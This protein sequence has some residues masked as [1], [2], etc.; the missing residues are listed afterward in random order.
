MT[1]EF[2]NHAL[3]DLSESAQGAG[4]ADL[5]A[6]SAGYHHFVEK[7]S[8]FISPTES[9]ETSKKFTTARRVFW[10][11]VLSYLLLY[12]AF[13]ELLG[14]FSLRLVAISNDFLR[15]SLLLIA[16]ILVPWIGIGIAAQLLLPLASWCF[17]P[18]PL[19][20]AVD[21]WQGPSL[22]GLIALVL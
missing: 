9:V 20:N 10:L 6:G 13:N 22:F 16:V 17:L 2:A 5:L 1:T 7:L 21:Y 14:P 18:M 4:R 3:G 19:T 8:N 11:V 15:G 12:F